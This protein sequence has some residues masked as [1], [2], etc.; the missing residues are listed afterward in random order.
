MNWQQLPRPQ[1][2]FFLHSGKFKNTVKIN[3]FVLPYIMLYEVTCS[4]HIKLTMNTVRRFEAML[5]YEIL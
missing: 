3:Y 4:K 2:I 1:T 5:V